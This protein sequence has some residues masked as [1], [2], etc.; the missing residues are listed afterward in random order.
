MAREI[1]VEI[2]GKERRLKYTTREG[3][4]L[5][6][7]FGKTPKRL[8]HE[9]IAPSENGRPTADFDPEVVVAALYMGL[10]HELGRKDTEATVE[11][12][13]DVACKAGVAIHVVNQIVDAVMLDGITGQSIDFEARR[14]AQAAEEDEPAAATPPDPDDDEG[15]AVRPPDN[16]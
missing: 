9:D 11:Q 14:A 1:Y 4:E 6:R 2:G 8:L 3:I 16:P 7:R 5:K 10:R 13:F 12:W 15:K